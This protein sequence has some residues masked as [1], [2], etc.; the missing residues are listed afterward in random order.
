MKTR[1]SSEMQIKTKKLNSKRSISLLVPRH[2]PIV[3]E[4]ELIMNR[5]GLSRSEVIKYLE[6]RFRRQISN[7]IKQASKGNTIVLWRHRYFNFICS[8]EAIK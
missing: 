4:A 1:R 6:D 3:V 7:E 2:N 5:F 8:L